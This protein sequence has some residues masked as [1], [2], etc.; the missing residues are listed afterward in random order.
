M[1]SKQTGFKRGYWHTR[2]VGDSLPS[3]V[4][5]SMRADVPKYVVASAVDWN[6]EREQFVTR[7]PVLVPTAD[8][9][10]FIGRGKRPAR[11]S[12]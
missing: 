9:T 3:L 6:Q 11:V 7:G 2:P 1:E 8:L 4:Y 12:R 5:V 10:T